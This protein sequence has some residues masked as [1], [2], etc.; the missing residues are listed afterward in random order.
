V[1]VRVDVAVKAAVAV[2]VEVL[3]GDRAAVIVRVGAGELV[4]VEDG[5]AVSVAGG[6][7]A[8]CT[9]GSLEGSAVH[10]TLA[11]RR[12]IQVMKPIQEDN[13]CICIT[14]LSRRL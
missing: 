12:N 10:A 3:V 5:I 11:R 4:N 7:V 2:T 13:L 9:S 14:S 6:A 1:G 8:V